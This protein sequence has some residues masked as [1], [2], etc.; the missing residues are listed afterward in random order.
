MQR[1]NRWLRQVM[2]IE[3]DTP[4]QGNLTAEAQLTDDDAT[5]VRDMLNIAGIAEFQ[6]ENGI[7]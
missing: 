6:M 1:E 5:S 2:S 4:Y 3:E 7:L